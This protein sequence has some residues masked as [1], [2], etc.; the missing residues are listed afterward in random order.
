VFSFPLVPRNRRLGPKRRVQDVVSRQRR[1]LQRS[2]YITP[3]E[4]G[5]NELQHVVRCNPA[6]G[7]HGAQ[8]TGRLDRLQ[9]RTS[10]ANL[11]SDKYLFIYFVRFTRA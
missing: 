8:G 5:R 11:V 6:C 10:D 1:R 4:T 9:N 7:P 2:V 3:R